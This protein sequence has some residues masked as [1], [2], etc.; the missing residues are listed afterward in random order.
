MYNVPSIL[1]VHE[2]HVVRP[3]CKRFNAIPSL[4][5]SSV[6]PFGLGVKPDQTLRSNLVPN[7]KQLRDIHIER[8]VWLGAGKELVYRG[9]GC[10]Y[11]VCGRPG[12]LQEVE[13]DFARLEVYIRVADWRYKADGGRRER[14]RIGNVDVEEPAAT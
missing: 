7:P 3:P 8:T 5:P 12:A 9:H 1:H 2:C 6:V 13:A 4:P 10:R 11:C 14:V